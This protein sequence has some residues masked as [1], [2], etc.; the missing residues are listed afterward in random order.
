M[1]PLRMCVSVEHT[2]EE[3]VLVIA[4]V[5]KTYPGGIQAL[6]GV[7]LRVSGGCVMSLLGPNGAGKTTLVKCIVGLITP[8]SGT[9]RFCGKD[10][11]RNPEYGRERIGVVF[12]EVN[13]IYG[14]LSVRENV[15]YY[16]YLNGLSYEM[17]MKFLATWVP[18]M[19]LEDKLSTPGF[20]LSR[21]MK[22]KV[23]LMIAML[24]DPDLLILD[25]PTLGLDVPS[26]RQV[27]EIIQSLCRQERRMVL[28]TTHDMALAQE[29][30]DFYCF[31]HQ[32]K[33][34]WH[35]SPQDLK[36]H[37]GA[38]VALDRAFEQIIQ[39]WR[40]DSSEP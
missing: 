20:K 8:D 23:A 21:G 32:G 38:E 6:K 15:L 31:I 36:R 25:E 30:S 29:V 27:I 5:S 24:K 3:R 40:D 26:R 28:L 17:A 7:S 1:C 16:A 4:D 19:Q 39:S 33:I 37:L 34:L 18:R 2:I 10:L 11:A 13:N 9:I 12:E 14:Y 22:Q 35:G